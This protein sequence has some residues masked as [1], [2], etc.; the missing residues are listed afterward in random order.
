MSDHLRLAAKFAVL[1]AV[2]LMV[3]IAVAVACALLGH[4]I[5]VLTVG[6]AN[7]AA[8]DESLPMYF[9]VA[10]TYLAAIV[11]GLL[12]F[13]AGWRRFLRRSRIPDRDG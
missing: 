6:E 10:C 2:A 4:Q 8:I 3:G 1:V 12:V 13:V 11:A 5:L 7:I 9:L